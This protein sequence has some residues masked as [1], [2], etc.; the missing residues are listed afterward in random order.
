M[1]IH[2]KPFLVL[3]EVVVLPRDL[4]LIFLANFLWD[5]GYGLYGFILPVYIR[6]LG[7]TIL[8]VGL[9]YLLMNAIYFSSMLFGGFIADKFDRKKLALLYWV[10]TAPTP[11]IYS[12]ATSWQHLIPGAIL[13]NFAL[14]SPAIDAYIASA[15]PK[16]RL[17]RAFTLTQAGYSLGMIFSPL[18][19]A[20]LLTLTYIRWLFR[21]AF[22][23]FSVSAVTISFISPQVPEKRQR[24][25]VISDIV[26]IARNRQLISWIFLFIP[27]A[28]VTSMSMPFISTLLEDLYFL[29]K[30]AIL[31]ISSI[32]SV[33][34]VVLATFLGWF[35]DRYG[36]ARGLVVGLAFIVAGMIFLEIPAFSPFLPLA[37]FLVGG[38]QVTVS[39]SSSIVAKYSLV[40]L[41]GTIFGLY[42]LIIGIGEICGPYAGGMLY[43][44]SPTQ[45][46]FWT[47]ISLL[48]LS[49]S[50]L[51]WDTLISRGKR[52]RGP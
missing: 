18:L 34:Q 39:L 20:Y 49:F 11:L 40:R 43:K 36:I 27:I 17:A 13:Y 9:F 5:C 16:E 29:Q 19:G 6:D 24:W 15:A 51:I 25:S 4:K 50:V 48:A 33:G 52:A 38:R 32:I 22:I 45:P 44:S 30:P 46:F 26:A 2:F 21:I 41:R 42:M 23:F 8:E 3:K 12:F 28:F 1:L 37:A 10:Q 31:V 47:S 7:G 14:F 35:G